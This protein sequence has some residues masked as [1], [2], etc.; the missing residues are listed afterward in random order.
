MVAANELTERKE[1]M[2]VNLGLCQ[3][4]NTLDKEENIRI[5]EGMIR[6]AAG[7][8][9]DI[10]VLPE[11]WNC[12]YSNKF[13]RQYSETETGRTV[14][15][16]SEISKE[17]E[18]YLIGGSI[19]EIDIAKEMKHEIDA[20][21]YNTC[22]AFDKAGSIIGKHRKAHLFDID[23]KNGISFKESETLTAGQSTTVIDTEYGKIGIAICYD[24][25]FPEFIRKETLE[26]AQIIILPAAFNLTTG[27]AHWELSIRARAL[28]N[29]VYFAGVSPA[30][31]K[32]KG[33]KAYGNTCVSNPW[34]K[35]IG[36]LGEK[37][38]LLIC[39]LDLDYLDEIREQLPLLK[40][41]KPELY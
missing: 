31:N 16:M 22:F 10:V 11:M 34:G 38:D 7:K 36:K 2:L 29:Q 20:K 28:D 39:Q 12:P 5:A 17:L 13:F 15:W 26:G 32:G 21:V 33:Y 1:V 35:I 6:E 3:M 37:Q 9:A 40:H 4:L 14:K 41:R 25:R 18:I 30:R 24:I 27:P 19:P 8:G 23:I